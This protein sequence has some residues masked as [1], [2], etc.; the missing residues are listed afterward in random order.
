[1]VFAVVRK[2]Y[3]NVSLFVSPSSFSHDDAVL[4]RSGPHSLRISYLGSDPCENA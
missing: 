2:H 4:V 3:R 1:M